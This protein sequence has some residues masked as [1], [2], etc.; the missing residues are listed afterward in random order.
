MFLPWIFFSLC[1]TETLLSLLFLNMECIWEEQLWVSVV[2]VLRFGF[3]GTSNPFT[4]MSSCWWTENPSAC[5]WFPGSTDL[6][7]R[8]KVK[9]KKTTQTTH[10]QNETNKN[11]NTGFSLVE[12][13]E[14][15]LKKILL[16][17]PLHLRASSVLGKIHNLAKEKH[18]FSFRLGAKSNHSFNYRW[19]ITPLNF[20]Q[21]T[22]ASF[23]VLTDGRWW[24]KTF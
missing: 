11:N 18:S 4:C 15:R 5:F 6:K 10:T 22:S 14:C 17:E 2:N 3:L 23:C 24:M 7:Q 1:T 19:I 8:N 12:A 20:L 16:T 9:K 13:N 21:I